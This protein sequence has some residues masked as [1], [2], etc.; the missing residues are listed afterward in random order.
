M[1]SA[2]RPVSPRE[3]YQVVE[4][5]AQEQEASLRAQAA[6]EE[7]GPS[8]ESEDLPASPAPEDTSS[9]Q[10]GSERNETENALETEDHIPPEN[11]QNSQED[12]N[13]FGSLPDSQLSRVAKKTL[14]KSPAKR[15]STTGT[16]QSLHEDDF[17][18]LE[19]TVP[20]A[21]S[22]EKKTNGDPDIIMDFHQAGDKARK[23]VLKRRKMM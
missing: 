12:G 11:L 8:R 22:G 20:S 6:D 23:N 15:A 17:E 2:A 5:E 13:L 3:D 10:G 9:D 21:N 19:S 18:S 16:I 7:A 1:S 4:Q 14:K